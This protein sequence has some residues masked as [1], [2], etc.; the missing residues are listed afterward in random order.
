MQMTC[1]MC[2]IKRLSSALAFLCFSCV[3][4]SYNVTDDIIFDFKWLGDSKQPR[5]VLLVFF[6]DGLDR[7]VM[8]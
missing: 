4:A 2:Q 5:E 7:K 6:I 3:I 1:I 8:L